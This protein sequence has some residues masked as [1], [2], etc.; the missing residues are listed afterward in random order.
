MQLHQVFVVAC[1]IFSCGLWDL[2]PSPEIKPG[3]PALGT[4]TS[5][6]HQGSPNFDHFL[7]YLWG[8]W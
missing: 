2:V 1:G 5:L 7:M 4:Q 6:D 3:P 8:G